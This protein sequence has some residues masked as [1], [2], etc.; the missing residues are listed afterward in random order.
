MKKLRSF[1]F[2]TIMLLVFLTA[3]SSCK[4]CSTKSDDRPNVILV[5]TDDMSFSDFTYYNPKGPRTPVIDKFADES[6]RL[7][8]FHV[9][10]TCSPTRAALLTGRDADATGSWHTIMGRCN[11]R[12]NEITMADIFKKNGYATGIYNKWHLGDNYPFR[13][14]ERGFEDVVIH[15]GGGIGQQAD[16][17]GNSNVMPSTYFVN[18]KP[19]QLTDEDDGIEGAFSTN[20]FFTYAMKFIEKNANEKKPFFAYIPTNTAHGPHLHSPPDAREGISVRT[21]TIENIDKNMGQL[22]KFLDDKGIADNTILIFTTDNGGPNNLRGGKGSEFEGGHRVPFFIRWKNGGIA[23]TKEMS[24]EVDQLTAH[25]DLLPT[26]M[27]WCNLEDVVQ[28]RPENLKIFGKSIANIIDQDSKDDNSKLRERTI[29]IDNQ[30]V[31]NLTKYKQY[32]VCKDE[33]NSSGEITHKWRLVQSKAEEPIMLFD[34]LTDLKQTNDLSSNAKN[35]AIIEELKKEYESWWTKVSKYSAPYTRIIIGTEHEPITNLNSQDWLSSNV[36]SQRQ[37]ASGARK[38]AEWAVEF[39]KTASYKVELR[40]W[41]VEVEN[42]T[43]L[44]SSFPSIVEGAEPKALP[45]A[46]ANLKLWNDKGVVFEK[47]IEVNSNADFAKFD[48]KDLPAGEYFLKGDFF[49][50]KDKFLAGSYYAYV[51][52][53]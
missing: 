52:A 7:T 15:L 3:F 19:V 20:F 34:L 47:K 24:R 13:P 33:F 36:W 50:S 53:K 40:R 4:A 32:S 22:I 9:S 16:Y 12:S 39:A 42:Q 18:D 27:Q 51:S 25:I 28:N 46:K 35:K 5:M 14:K 49:D 23:G 2:L 1:Q 10:P 30:R 26:F 11:L 17:F 38:S 41:P 8:D 45:I 31:K 37:A 44:S 6:V 21:A 29:I 43:T 48:L